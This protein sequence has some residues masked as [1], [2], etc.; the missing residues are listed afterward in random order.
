MANENHRYGKQDLADH[1]VYPAIARA[2][3]FNLHENELELLEESMSTLQSPKTLV[4]VGPGTEVLPF[5]EN[6]EIASRMIDGGNIV[7]M[8]YSEKICKK[9]PEHLKKMGIDKRFTIRGVKGEYDPRESSNTIF[10]E[11]RN[12][13]DGYSFPDSSVSAIDMTVAVHH[14]TQYESDI[15]DFCREAYRVLV[16]EGIL[17][18]G[19]GRVDMKH[20]ERKLKRVAKDLLESGE[21]GVKVID[22]RYR[23][24]PPRQ[25]YFGVHADNHAVVF[26]NETGMMSIT[27]QDLCRARKHLEENGYKQVFQDEEKLVMPYIDHGMEEDFQGLIMPVRDYYDA[28]R[29]TT[30][31][32]IPDM[33]RQNFLDAIGKEQSDA[34][35]GIV[36]F[37]SH[38]DMVK[39]CIRKAGFSIEKTRYTANGPFWNV[40]ARKPRGDTE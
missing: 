18:I 32:S 35:R 3:L 12:I 5:S 23:D 1:P 21:A 39:D 10:I 20:N 37:Y 25:S 14:A 26:I 11:Q 29:K 15:T 34:E 31:K 17:H 38:P 9:I 6:I 22:A 13:V 24:R 4:V 8:D 28:I 30:L 19:E 40:V 16:P 7:L 2:L 27:S 33:H 36:E